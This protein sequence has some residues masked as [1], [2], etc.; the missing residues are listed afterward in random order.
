MAERVYDY[1]GKASAEEGLVLLDG[2][3]GI[4]IAMTP[5]AAER[6]GQDLL[7]AA[8]EA[9]AQDGFTGEAAK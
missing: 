8:G 7:R 3:D 2:P 6:T 5:D 1:P 4:A 9:R